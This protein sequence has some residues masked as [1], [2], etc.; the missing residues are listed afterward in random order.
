[1]P[2]VACA[3][4]REEIIKFFNF[5]FIVTLFFLFSTLILLGLYLYVII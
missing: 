2:K 3:G 4:K 1:M 5:N